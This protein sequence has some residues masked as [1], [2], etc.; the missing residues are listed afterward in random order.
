M[1]KLSVS[2]MEELFSLISGDRALYLPLEAE[3]LAQFGQWS[4]GA[5]VQLDKL[6]TVK[7]PKDFFF[8]HTEDIAAFKVRNK[9]ITI[10]DMRSDIE[11]FAVFGVRACDA[12]SLK[13]LD[14]VFLSEPVDTFYESRRQNGTIITT[15]CLQPEE[16]CF[17]P[18]FNIDAANPGGDAATWLLGDTLY[19]KSLTKRGD[20]LTG[21]IKGLFEQAGS[22]EQAAI[23]QAQAKAKEI[24][25]KLPFKGLNLEGFTGK[26]LMEKFDSPQWAEL[27]P[28]CLGC[29]TCIPNAANVL[30]KLWIVT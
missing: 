6:V 24:F 4:P 21:K 22:Q 26:A 14:R 28:A 12:E 17:C 29:G 23:E 30:P 11:P 3:G 1:L 9:E 16:S 25:D 20:E 19:W 13:L 5:K 10:K 2:R 27:Y 18:A 8:P 7:S 15:A